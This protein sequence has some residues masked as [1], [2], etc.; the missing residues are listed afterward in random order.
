MRQQ[1]PPSAMTIGSVVR[2]NGYDHTHYLNISTT[3]TETDQDGTSQS[4]QS[5]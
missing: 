1:I 2:N 5:V 4:I 3:T